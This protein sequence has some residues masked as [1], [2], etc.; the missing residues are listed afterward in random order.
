MDVWCSKAGTQHCCVHAHPCCC[1]GR[2]AGRT[3]LMD[4]PDDARVAMQGQRSGPEGQTSHAYPQVWKWKKQSYTDACS[5]LRMIL[6]ADGAS[7]ATSTSLVQFPG[8]Y[9]AGS[10][11]QLLCARVLCTAACR[12]PPCSMQCRYTCNWPMPTPGFA[13]HCSH[14][15]ANPAQSMVIAHAFGRCQQSCG[16]SK[17]V[18]GH[19]H[20][21]NIPWAMQMR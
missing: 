2:H 5:T 6:Q 21:S 18:L 13:F 14:G 12:H 10:A 9:E 17:A 19:V 8:Q 16:N 15:A 7:K 4:R 20:P 1:T 11:R 3:A